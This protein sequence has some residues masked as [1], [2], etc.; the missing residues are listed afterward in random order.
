MFGERRTTKLDVLSGPFWRDPGG[1]AFP[2][3]V[4]EVSERAHLGWFL[5]GLC[6]SGFPSVWRWALRGTIAQLVP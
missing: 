4:A 3:S 2:V 1:S 5:Q 6:A